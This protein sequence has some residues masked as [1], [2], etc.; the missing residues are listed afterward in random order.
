[1]SEIATDLLIN[2]G[3]LTQVEQLL[4]SE[5]LRNSETLKRLLKFLAER[6]ATGEADQLK[7]Y[8]IAVDALAKPSTY[9]PRHD[10]AVRI[11][12]GRLRQKLAEYYRTEG[13]DDPLII[14]LPKGHFKLTCTPR[15]AMADVAPSRTKGDRRLPTWATASMWLTLMVAVAWG[16]YSIVRIRQAEATSSVIATRWTP[17]LEELWRPFIATSR[18]TI[19][20][21][22]DPLFVELERGSEIYYRDK[23]THDWSQAL[24]SPGIIALRKTFKNSSMQPSRYYTSFGEVNAAFLIGRLLGARES[25]ISVVRNSQLSWQQLADNNVVFVGVRTFFGGQLAAMPLQPELVFADDGIRNLHP[26]AGEPG[27][28]SDQFSTAPAEEGV[29]YA[30]VTHSPGPMG[31]TEAESFMSNRA[32]GYVGAVQWFTD[33]DSARILVGDLRKAYGKIPRYY[34]VVLRVQFKDEVPTQTSLV[35]SR[36]LP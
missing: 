9:D 11:Q 19:V 13:K 22:Q 29:V 25:N 28:F 7:E 34:Q 35:L 31:S 1:M 32:A 17:E 15:I 6:S 14:D 24:N 26:R 5:T 4:H 8:T 30:L 12:I 18:P 3:M 2:T 16:G 21:F 33:P 10:S 23:S 20:A 27:S 36:E